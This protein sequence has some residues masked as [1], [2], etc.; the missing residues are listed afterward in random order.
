[1]VFAGVVQDGTSP[2]LVNGAPDFRLFVVPAR[3]MIIEDTWAGAT[4]MRSSG[5]HAARVEGAVVDDGFSYSFGQPR[6]LDR[7]LYRLPTYLCFAASAVG[8]VLGV[9][10]AAIEGTCGSARTKRSSADG[11]AWSDLV[12]VRQAVADAVAVHQTLR[13]G[14]L[15]ALDQLQAR[16]G[17]STEVAPDDRA[18][19]WATLFHTVDTARETI[20]RLAAASSSESYMAGHLTE[21]AS[22]DIHAIAVAFERLR[23]LNESAGAVLVGAAPVNPAF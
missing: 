19:A 5:S 12:T 3:E 14:V 18:V 22:R 21:R 13:A 8:I 23:S 20:S 16:Y 4:A 17:S 2:R 9:L 10:G 15:A 1:V 11:S 7:S 6:V